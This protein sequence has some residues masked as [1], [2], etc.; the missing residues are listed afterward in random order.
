[1]DAHYVVVFFIIMSLALLTFSK[2]EHVFLLIPMI[3]C[4]TTYLYLPL[5]EDLLLN[6][7]FKR[8]GMRGIVSGGGGGGGRVCKETKW[9]LK[10]EIWKRKGKKC[11]EKMRDIR[12]ETETL[13]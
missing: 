9:R 10:Y 11:R 12:N 6:E 4:H 7:G 3:I 8:R 1:M 13:Q 5:N 2:N